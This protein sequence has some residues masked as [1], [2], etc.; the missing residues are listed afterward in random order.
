VIV[1]NLFVDDSNITDVEDG[2]PQRPYNTV[3]EAINAAVSG[4]T[5]AVAAGVYTEN[6]RIQDKTVHIYGGYLGGSSADYANGSGGNFNQRNIAINTTHLQGNGSD[7][8][9]T[10]LNAGVSTVDG[11]RITGGT[12][13]LIPE[14]GIVGGGVYVDGGSPTLS[15]NLIENN[16]T[17]P[18][19]QPV[20]SEPVGGGIFAENAQI[21]ILDNVIRNNR[22]GRG[23]GIGINGGAVVIRGNTVQGNIGVSDHGGGLYLAAPNITV[24][25]NRIMGNEIGRDLGYGWGGGIIVFGADSAAMLSYNLITG[26]YAPSVGSGVFIDDG[27][28]A[29]LD[30]ELIYANVCPDGGTTGGVGVYVDGYDEIGSQATLIHT[31]VAGHNCETMGGNG[32]YVEV[33]SGVTIRNSLFWGN[34]GD[35]FF[36]DATSQIT[37]TYTLSQES[38][39][40]TGNLT[41]DPLFADAANHDYHLRSTGGRWDATA[42]GGSGGWVVD[43]QHSPA[44]DAGD[45]A[46]AFVQEPV[47]HG[48]RANLGVYGNTAQAS[49]SG[50]GR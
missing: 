34:G 29:V 48:G 26:N 1:A 3:Q 50:P 32:L 8:T 30:H 21:Q 18:A 39:P 45:P 16:D 10:L 5:V 13:S 41:A 2:S 40:G 25:H 27:A 35:D 49:K 7:S 33:Y 43:S 14:F 22:S 24:S 4:Q 38:L 19:G 12:R 31:T 15:H 17:R 47:P 44:I 11:F 46:S 9:V 23:G 36:V 20:E 37:A 42:N 6:V 28:Q